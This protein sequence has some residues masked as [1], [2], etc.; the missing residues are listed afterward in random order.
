MSDTLLTIKEVA[1]R[2]ALGRTTVYELI[3][4][5]E[6]K[7]IKVGRCRRIPESAV[8]EWIRHQVDAQEGNQSSADV[9]LNP[10][11]NEKICTAAQSS[12][13][14]APEHTHNNSQHFALRLTRAKNHIV[15]P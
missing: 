6:I 1:T 8:D 14:R 7:T 11:G 9:T 2:L 10:S 13:D 5:H 12:S 3:G 15:E 4:R